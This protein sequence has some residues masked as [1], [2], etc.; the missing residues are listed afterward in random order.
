MYCTQ[1]V[2]MS[3]R[4]SLPVLSVDCRRTGEVATRGSQYYLSTGTPVLIVDPGTGIAVSWSSSTGAG[5]LRVKISA[6]GT[7]YGTK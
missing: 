2:I 3:L 4:L 5:T 6:D 1:P 7:Y